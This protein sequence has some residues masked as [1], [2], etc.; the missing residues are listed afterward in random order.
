MTFREQLVYNYQKQAD[1]ASTYS[2]LYAQLFGKVSEWLKDEAHPVTAWLV[3]AGKERNPFEMT[4]LLVAGLHEAVLSNHP[5]AIELAAF[6]PTVGGSKSPEDPTLHT[7][8]ES[9]ILNMRPHLTHV[10]QTANVQTN[11]TGRGSSWLLPVAFTPWPQVELLDLGASAGL[12]LIADQSRFEFFHDDQSILTLGEGDQ[13]SLE[14]SVRGL[15]EP[16]KKLSVK[17]P[18]VKSRRGTDLM[19]FHLNVEADGQ[20]L[21]SYVWGDQPTRL[22]RLDRALTNYQTVQESDVPIQLAAV[23]LPFE[24]ETYL[25]SLPPSD[26]PLVIYNTIVTMYFPNDRPQLEE[27]VANWASQQRRPVL[28][29]QWE[30]RASWMEETRSEEEFGWAG[31]TADFWQ[32]GSHHQF[33]L[34]WVQPHGLQVRL[35]DGLQQWADYWQ[36]SA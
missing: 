3:E 5:A 10:I 23:H 33:L 21:K 25:E 22:A 20:R 30:P 28:W 34:G 18:Q 17:T 11:E 16:L 4:L 35:T 14:V 1:F 26:T 9:A 2:P 32:H 8:L 31:W 19:P 24:L 6:Y 12:N 15:Y 27:T 13:T 29:M 36:Q 7:I